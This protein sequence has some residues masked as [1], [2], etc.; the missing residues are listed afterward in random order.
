MSLVED[1]IADCDIRI[2]GDPHDRGEIPPRGD[3]RI[4]QLPRMVK[5]AVVMAAA[6]SRCRWQPPDSGG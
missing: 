1:E 2:K 3:L 4:P 6:V 5:P